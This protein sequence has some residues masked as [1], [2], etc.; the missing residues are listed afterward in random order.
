MQWKLICSFFF[1]IRKEWC[2]TSPYVQLKWLVVIFPSL[3][4]YWLKYNLI[5]NIKIRVRFLVYTPKKTRDILPCMMVWWITVS[6]IKIMYR[7][8][9]NTI[10][11]IRFSMADLADNSLFSLDT[12]WWENNRFPLNWVISYL[13]MEANW[14]YGS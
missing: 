3:I 11:D 13:D 9:S 8:L 4:Q 14:R 2:T 5:K 6:V 7:A 12:I 1:K 10:D